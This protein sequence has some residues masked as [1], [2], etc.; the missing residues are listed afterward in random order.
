MNLGQLTAY[1]GA[2]ISDFEK[3]MASAQQRM[4]QTGKRMQK[5]GKR[6][7]MFVTAPLVGLGVA[8]V[9]ASMEFAGSMNKI[10]GLVGVG[11]EQVS[12]WNAEILR[13]A[14]E[15]A[16]AP[17]ELADAMYY[18]TSAGWRGAEAMDLL[19]RSA[20][21]AAAGLGEAKTIAHLTS[22][23]MAAYGSDVLSAEQATDILVAS[24]RE[25]KLAPEEL[26]A[27]MASVLPI[28]SELG[29]Q[30]NEVGAAMAAMSRSGTNAAEASTALRGMLMALTK[31][32][33]EQ[34]QAFAAIGTSA[35]ELRDML[36]RPGG[37]IN[38]LTLLDDAADGN[39]EVMADM[40]P[41]VRA[42]TGVLD[43][44]GGSADGTREIFES[45]N[46]TVGL[47]DVA[48]ESA[49]ETMGFK[50]KQAMVEARAGLTELGLT[51]QKLV[52]PILENSIERIRKLNEWFSNLDDGTK[53]LIVV[54]GGVAAAI[55]PVLIVTG[56]LIRNFQII[57]PL[58]AKARGVMLAF[59]A[60]M[61]ANPAVAV[62]SAITAVAGALYFWNRRASA[63]EKL[64]RRLNAA[65][66]EAIAPL[67]EERAEINLLI[68]AIKQ[69]EEGTEARK[70]A[71]DRLNDA[72]PHVLENYNK[73]KLSNEE[74]VGVMNDVNATIEERIR[75]K[76]LEA[77][78][79]EALQEAT[80]AQAELYRLEREELELRAKIQQLREDGETDPLLEER[81]LIGVRKAREENSKLLEAANKEYKDYNEAL[82]QLLRTKK[83]H[84][85]EIERTS[86]VIQSEIQA[87]KKSLLQHKKMYEQYGIGQEELARLTRRLN[88]LRDELQAVEE[89]EKEVVKA[90]GDVVE[91]FV[92]FDA[93]IQR[94]GR[95]LK[96]LELLSIANQMKLFKEPIQDART[97]LTKLWDYIAENR[98]A[99]FDNIDS[100]RLDEWAGKWENAARR[101]ESAINV[102]MTNVISDFVTMVGQGE[103]SSEKFGK[104]VLGLFADVAEQVGRIAI[105]TGL[106][107]EGIRK[108]LQSL[109]P[110][111]ALA[112]GAA[113]LALA[114]VVRGRLNA[115]AEGG[116]G[117][118][119]LATGG[120]VVRSG[121]FDVGERGKERVFLPAGSAVMSN[122][123]MRAG[124]AERLIAEVSGNDLRIILDRSDAQ[125]GNR[126]ALDFG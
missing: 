77:M 38:V 9:R 22:S 89:E 111:A 2:D 51:L 37:L 61:M 104:M 119:G 93:E 24:V 18:I 72:Y 46:D 3:K 109:N 54:L 85:K 96:S 94:V 118:Q 117:V 97:E 81:E 91:Q 74:L 20:R 44:M 98:D 45:M 28:A 73:E 43:L 102:T 19:E 60:A 56:T 124:G 66:E 68:G 82:N 39:V 15:V 92:E 121:V 30:F 25:G 10:V 14:G 70:R 5:V 88:A 12:S 125:S 29:V 120:N 34:E 59:N 114:G 107:I 41:N 65:K 27:S 55:G 84:N 62:A 8:S 11:E 47:A 36:A 40:F 126:R 80:K 86:Q 50:W 13:M 106:A 87:V 71:I 23:A 64:Q 69:A 101:I 7:S 67:M 58:I 116:S 99:V 31:P 105:G 17:K 112:A 26:A 90:T 42:L 32:S 33:S 16:M 4:E 35:S 63:T 95:N 21:A 108:A 49:S 103:M 76:A 123:D 115:I 83:N 100:G 75:L 79:G 52:L 122:K 6:M 53:R 1:L 57:L 113:L 48:F 78:A 110:F